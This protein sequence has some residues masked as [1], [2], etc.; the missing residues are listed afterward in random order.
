MKVVI[1]SKESST[2]VIL[3][4]SPR[5]LRDRVE[6]PKIG[7][8]DLANLSSISKKLSAEFSTTI[9]EDDIV[10][11]YQPILCGLENELLYQ[12]YGY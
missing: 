4:P 5:E 7:G 3:K 8:L 6:I 12:Q 11:A 2:K 9:T 1:P 10:N